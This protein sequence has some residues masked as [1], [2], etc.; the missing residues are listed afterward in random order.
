MIFIQ[1]LS[2][3]INVNSAVPIID[4]YDYCNYESLSPIPPLP[5]ILGYSEPHG[6]RILMYVI[7]GIILIMILSLFRQQLLFIMALVAYVLK[8][9]I[10]SSAALSAYYAVALALFARFNVSELEATPS[11]RLTLAVECAVLPTVMLLLGVYSVALERAS[12]SGKDPVTVPS[13][14]PRM[15]VNLRYLSNT[16]EQLVLHLVAS[17][18]LSLQLPGSWLALLP[19]NALLFVVAR[20]LFWAGYH[21]GPMW[22]AT[23]YALTSVPTTLALLYA[24][25]NAALYLRP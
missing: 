2:Q 18:A 23:G 4:L 25:T 8:V 12:G 16:L 10:L 5:Q 3:Q 17:A 14:S 6:D 13:A 20:A 21:V 9:M 11:M 1:K 24:A 7:I 22:R 19:A 15:A